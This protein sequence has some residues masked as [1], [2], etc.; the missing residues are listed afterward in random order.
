MCSEQEALTGGAR[1]DNRTAERT[2]QWDGLRAALDAAVAHP[3]QRATTEEAFTILVRFGQAPVHGTALEGF[4]KNAEELGSGNPPVLGGHNTTP[5]GRSGSANGAAAALST[6]CLGASAGVI[7]AKGTGQAD[8]RCPS[9]LSGALE[10]AAAPEPGGCGEASSVLLGAGEIADLAAELDP[11]RRIDRAFAT[12]AETFDGNDASSVAGAAAARGRRRQRHYRSPLHS[13]AVARRCRNWTDKLEE[14]GDLLTTTQLRLGRRGQDLLL[15]GTADTTAPVPPDSRPPT[16]MPE[17]ELIAQAKAV[18]ASA[19][20]RQLDEANSGSNARVVDGKGHDGAA[21]LTAQIHRHVPLPDRSNKGVRAFEGRGFYGG[22]AAASRRGDAGGPVAVLEV[23]PAFGRREPITTDGGDGR[24]TIG[25]NLAFAASVLSVRVLRQQPGLIGVHPGAVVVEDT[26]SSRRVDA[27]GERRGEESA[28]PADGYSPVPVRIVCERLEGWRSL[29][30]VILAHGPLAMPSEIAAGE[31]GEG[32]RVLRLWGRQLAS[33]LECLSSASLLVRDLRMS[34]VFVSPDGSMVKVVDFPSLAT[35]SSDTGLVSSEAP[36]LDGDIHG[37]T[38]PL[39]PP[40]ALAIRGG[41]ENGGVS[42]SSGGSIEDSRRDGVSLVLADTGSPGPFPITAAW[43]VWT[44]GILLFELAFGY[45]PPAYGESLRRGLSSLALDNATSGGT[46]VTPV[47]KLDD[48]VTEIQY[49]FLS[50]VGGLTNK[51]EGNGVGLAT[52]H[53]GDSPL[54]KALGCMSLGAAIGEGDPFHVASSAGVGGGTSAIWDDGWKSVHRFRRA[55]V[56]RQLQIEEG[57]DLDVTTWQTFQEK[58]RDHLDVSVASAVAATTPWSP[59]SGGDEGGGRKKI[60]AVHHDHGAPFCS[61]RM[62]RQA[63]EAA[64]DRTVA[65]LVGADPRGTGRLPFSVVRGVLRDELQLSFSTSE[66]ELVAFC[67][68]D[69]GGPEGSGGDAEGRDADSPVGQSYREGEGNVLYIPLVHVLREASLS[70][71]A[72]A[73]GLSR[74]LR[75]GDDTLHPPTP[76]SFV[77]LLFACLEPNPNRRP[78]SASL[79]GLP[80][81]SPRRQRTSGEDDRKAATEYM[82]G[83]GNDL[84]PT[85]ALRELVESRIQA[86]EAASSQ[87]ENSQEAV[88]TLNHHSATRARPVRGRGGDGASTNVGVGV[89]VE[90][91][92]ELEGLVHRSSPPVDRLGEDD[93]PQQ[94]RRV[95]LGHSK[96]IGEI[97]ETGVLVRAAALGLRFLDRD[98]VRAYSRTR[99][100]LAEEVW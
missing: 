73:P 96:L 42:D 57:G 2:I 27:V 28:D 62:T 38:M 33:T 19:A 84:S 45:P 85:M 29:R 14:V 90:A 99:V 78:S 98:E 88:S 11:M 20:R 81:L 17:H 68:R 66:A 92:K 97:F 79:L 89:L 56:R 71:A 32:L 3:Q 72:S 8:E 75:A 22:R 39:T 41:T 49:D 61:K 74:S 77:E 93:Y 9:G 100:P 13:Y 51:E 15:A 82:A 25:E 87:P 46:K 24:R 23:S 59:I 47:P 69:T 5:T 31:G 37:P 64:V 95:T 16:A 7:I 53:V 30:D 43:D 83:S 60:E 76:A 26:K 86:L 35:F 36:K 67:L 10:G 91:L 44:L 52:A 40:E 65:Q 50:A 80:F 6:T 12:L 34:T 48:L 70:S 21:I 18:M 4:A 63:A 94:A 55:W 1:Q 58:I 54:E